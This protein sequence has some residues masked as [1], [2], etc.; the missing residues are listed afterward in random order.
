MNL[1]CTHIKHLRLGS[2]CSSCDDGSCS[3]CDVCSSLRSQCELIRVSVRARAL[4]SCVPRPPKEAPIIGPAET[5][6]QS[7]HDRGKVQ[8][9]LNTCSVV[10][11][12]RDCKLWHCD[13]CPAG[14]QRGR[15]FIVN[16]QIDCILRH[17]GPEYL[18]FRVIKSFRGSKKSFPLTLR[19]HT[20]WIF[21]ER[22]KRNA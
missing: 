9:L 18:V 6:L 7:Q 3:E 1:S 4:Q 14:I 5:S 22:S 16:W 20:I 8:Q 21:N 19:N 11:K 17:G 10:C 12:Q 2:I 15:I 13:K